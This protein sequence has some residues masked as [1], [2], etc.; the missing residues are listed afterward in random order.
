VPRIFLVGIIRHPTR[1][2]SCGT[3][4]NRAEPVGPLTLRHDH[5]PGVTVVFDD[6]PDLLDILI[7]A[8]STGATAE[9]AARVIIGRAASSDLRTIRRKLNKLVDQ[10]LATRQ[11]GKRTSHGAEPDR[12]YASPQA[13][14]GK[15]QHPMNH[16]TKP[17]V[18]GAVPP[19]DKATGERSHSP[20]S[21]P[22][23]RHWTGKIGS[24]WTLPPLFK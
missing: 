8:G 13:A 3:S 20:L 15:K 12:W 9:D 2:L 17:L 24:H 18:T 14:L 5:T 16:R 6:H 23:D 10:Y 4:S 7:A 19:L 21:E 1:P 22:P 11:S